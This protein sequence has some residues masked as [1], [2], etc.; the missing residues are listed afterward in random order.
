ME[1]CRALNYSWDSCCIAS[2]TIGVSWRAFRAAWQKFCIWMR[3]GV[4]G[5]G[6]A[7]IVSRRFH[8]VESVGSALSGSKRIAGAG[9]DLEARALR[10]GPR[11]EFAGLSKDTSQGRGTHRGRVRVLVSRRARTGHGASLCSIPR[12]QYVSR[13]LRH[14]RHAHRAARKMRERTDRRTG[15]DDESTSSGS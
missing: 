12:G 10:R 15:Y 11:S 5:Y 1:L 2:A 8:R 14:A 7:K 3:S 9:I 4:T 13:E 6:F